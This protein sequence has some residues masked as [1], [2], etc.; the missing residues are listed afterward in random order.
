MTKLRDVR[1]GV[2]FPVEAKKDFSLPVKAQTAT[3]VYSVSYSMGIWGSFAEGKVADHF[4]LVPRLW[5]SGAIPSTPLVC[6]HGA[7]GVDFVFFSLFC[8]LTDQRRFLRRHK[9]DRAW[10]TSYVQQ[11]NIHT[12]LSRDSHKRNPVLQRNILCVLHLD[13]EYF[14]IRLHEKQITK[15]KRIAQ[16]QKKAKKRISSSSNLALKSEKAK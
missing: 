7:C 3:G 16:Q 10:F 5:M 11:H 2:R 1:S 8:I 15:L 14:I 12:F 13:S 4:H 9:I 6:L